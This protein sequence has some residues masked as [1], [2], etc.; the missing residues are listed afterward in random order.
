M[1]RQN[2]DFNMEEIFKAIEESSLDSS[3]YIGCDSAELGA[4]EV[5]YVT[6]IILHHDSCNGGRVFKDVKIEKCYN[7]RQKLIREVSFVAEHGEKLLDVIGDRNFEVHLD[8][9]PNKSAGSNVV[10]KEAVGYILGVLGIQPKLKPNAFAA[11]CAS[12]H[13][14]V[15]IR[16]GV[17]QKRKMRKRRRFFN[18]KRAKK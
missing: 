11:S 18:K 4:N 7:M 9:N 1:K 17:E 15:K 10:L 16:D 2:V 14:A 3:V 12:D 6:V 5:A 13:M 8:V